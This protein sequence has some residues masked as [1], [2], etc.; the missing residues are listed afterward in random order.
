MID[1]ALTLSFLFVGLVYTLRECLIDTHP[2]CCV[3][4]LSH[5]CGVKPAS[6]QVLPSI[7]TLQSILLIDIRDRREEVCPL[8]RIMGLADFLRLEL[9]DGLDHVDWLDEASSQHA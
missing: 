9:D 2:G 6:Q 5:Q 7:E 4:D 1:Y 8:F 3:E